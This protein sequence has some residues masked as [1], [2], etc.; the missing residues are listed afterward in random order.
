MWQENGE[1]S[2]GRSMVS[3]DRFGLNPVIQQTFQQLTTAHLKTSLR[4]APPKPRPFAALKTAPHKKG[5]PKGS[6]FPKSLKIKP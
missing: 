6:P 5:P 1:I 2:I 3:A 4:H